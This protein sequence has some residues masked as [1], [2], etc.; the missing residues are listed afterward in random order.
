MRLKERQLLEVEI[1]PRA[2]V[3]GALG[4]VTEGFGEKVSVRA[5]VLP[6]SGACSVQEGGLKSGKGLKIIIPKDIPVSEGD[7]V[8]LGGEMYT[9]SSVH[10]W[11]A[12]AELDCAKHI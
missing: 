7:G 3:K 8:W 4:S 6:Q 1:A 2:C 11:R 12:H 10:A 5:S 9:V